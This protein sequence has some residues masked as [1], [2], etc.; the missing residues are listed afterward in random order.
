MVTPG[1][2]YSLITALHPAKMVYFAETGR[3]VLS[4][5]LPTGWDLQWVVLLDGG[6]EQ[7]KQRCVQMC[8]PY[9][10]L[11][12]L[13]IGAVQPQAG[14]PV[15]RNL[16][17][18]GAKGEL[19]R[20]MDGDDVLPARALQRDIKAMLAHPEV[21]WCASA[22]FNLQADGS[23]ADEGG[24]LDPPEGIIRRGQLGVWWEGKGDRGEEH[25]QPEV[26]PV[27]PISFCI[28]APLLRAL[29]GWMGVAPGSEETGLVVALSE[30]T[31]GWFIPQIGL[32]YRIWTQSVMAKDMD[33]TAAVDAAAA[34][35]GQRLEAIRLLR[36]GVPYLG[37]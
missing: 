5:R 22:S 18:A 12:R 16:A 32:R 35:V 27:H 15:C 20:A 21:G 30:L 34:A 37:A 17:L 11:D 1:H 13:W 28:R 19:I 3:S 26:L 4:Q 8:A 31:A 7:D 6:T 23:P 25:E 24:W 14:L 36:A 9:G 29:G 33:N 2:T 10:R